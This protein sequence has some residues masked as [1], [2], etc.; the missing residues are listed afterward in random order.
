MPLRPNTT[1][2]YAV[3]DG[4]RTVRVPF[5]AHFAALRSPLVSLAL[6]L[7]IEVPPAIDR[8]QVTV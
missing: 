1:S 4:I 3:A 8:A 6:L 7:G 5:R 2:L